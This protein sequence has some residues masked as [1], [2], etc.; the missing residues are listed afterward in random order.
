MGIGVR[1]LLESRQNRDYF[2]PNA[3][4][5]LLSRSRASQLGYGFVTG[6]CT[7]FPTG[8]FTEFTTSPLPFSQ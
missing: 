4:R 1:V 7:Q 3:I 2:K 6:M 8:A 5:H